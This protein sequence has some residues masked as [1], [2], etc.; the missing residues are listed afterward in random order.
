MSFN[1]RSS[2]N[3]APVTLLVGVA[4]AAAMA[5]MN[6]MVNPVSLAAANAE[7]LPD[8]LIPQPIVKELPS[9][10]LAGEGLLRWFGFRI[11]QARLY[12]GE[13]YD[14]AKPLQEPIALELTYKRNFDSQSIV[15]SSADEIDSLGLG[16][17]SQRAQWS[18]QMANLFPDIS[19]GD[20]FAAIWTTA[21]QTLFVHNDRPVGEISDPAFGPAFFAIWLDERTSAPA[22]R[23]LLI[24]KS[25]SA[26]TLY[27]SAQ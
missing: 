23:A 2:M 5:S 22:L 13:S 12:V 26:A 7:T 4:M 3:K 18:T 21:G 9:A 17:E 16:T 14:K 19:E 6:P 15:Q 8:S 1:L 24:G 10:R 25:D 20:R 27:E 11:Y